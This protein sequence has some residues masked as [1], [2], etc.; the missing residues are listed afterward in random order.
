MI[1]GVG[2]DLLRIDRVERLWSKYG[3]HFA[4]KILL[5]EER[6]QFEQARRK[7]NFLAKAF[8]AKEAFVKALGTGFHGVGYRDAGVVSLPSGKPTLVFS[9]AMRLRLEALNIA[10][11]HVSLTDEDGRVMAFVV[12]E[13]R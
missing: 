10:G 11:G 3:E 9:A 4:N 13:T 7:G 12:L 8:A 2:T 5:P 6:A 1:Y